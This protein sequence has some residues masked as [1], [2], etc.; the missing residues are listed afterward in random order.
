M[1]LFLIRFVSTTSIVLT[2]SCHC[3]YFLITRVFPPLW[4]RLSLSFYVTDPAHGVMFFRPSRWMTSQQIQEVDPLTQSSADAA[5]FS[6]TTTGLHLLY[7]NVRPSHGKIP[8]H[9]HVHSIKIHTYITKHSH[10]RVL[11]V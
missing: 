1:F 5:S 11:H 2:L 3:T 7:F 9:V 8:M 6:V 4:R 10:S